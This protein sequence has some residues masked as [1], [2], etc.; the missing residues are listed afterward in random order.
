[1]VGGSHPK[2]LD[3]QRL[4]WRGDYQ[5]I[6]LVIEPYPGAV[7]QTSQ[8]IFWSSRVRRFHEEQALCRHWR[9]DRTVRRPSHQA[10]F[11]DAVSCEGN[12]IGVCVKVLQIGATQPL[13]LTPWPLLRLR[14]GQASLRGKG[15]VRL[16]SPLRGEAGREAG[17]NCHALAET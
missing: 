7:S 15:E 13:D 4:F 2:Q 3:K 10:A 14:S 5:A 12:E 6:F 8:D 11:D 1:M 16:P 9:R 17:A